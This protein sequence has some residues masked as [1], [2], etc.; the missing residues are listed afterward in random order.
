VQFLICKHLAQR[1]ASWVLYGVAPSAT[2]PVASYDVSS[3]GFANEIYNQINA[4]SVLQVAVRN[5]SSI[6]KKCKTCK[7]QD[8]TVFGSIFTK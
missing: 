8:T 2:F 6:V 3:C 4:F 5:I 7:E 1:I